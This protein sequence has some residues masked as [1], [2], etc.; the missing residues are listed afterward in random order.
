MKTV[1]FKSMIGGLLVSLALLI[2]VNTVQAK[3]YKLTFATNTPP[4]NWRGENEKLFLEEVEKFTKGKVKITAYWGGS[5]LKGKEILKGV[6]NQITSMGF[7]NIAYNPKRLMA[8]SAMMLSTKGPKK[9]EN[10]IAVFDRWYEEIPELNA[11]LKRF[12]QKVVYQYAVTPIG[13]TFTKPVNSLA[14]FKDRKVR[15]SIRWV[16]NILKSLGAVPVSV[17]WSDT[18]MALQTNAIEGVATQ[19]D[20]IRRGKL[21]EVAPYIYLLEDVW[22]PFPFTIT[23]N[24]RVWNRLP[25]EIQGQIKQAALSARKKAALKYK[26][27]YAGLRETHKKMGVTVVTASAQD[28]ELWVG[29]P[30]VQESI[31]TWIK[32]SKAAGMKN[33]AAVWDKMEKIVQEVTATEL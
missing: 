9:Y 23:I 25:K 18:Y 31:Q 7:V 2:T 32:E 22:L 24:E 30:A 28:T 29:N 8:H 17:P 27:F 13:V 1:S 26:T 15:T 33:P 20:A 14:D 4:S 3:T 11:E 5:L 12:K 19:Y 16:M 21:D 10:M 6:K